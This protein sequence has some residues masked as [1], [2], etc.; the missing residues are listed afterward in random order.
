MQR[1]AIS[2]ISPI[3]SILVLK[4]NSYSVLSLWVVHSW[5]DSLKGVRL[6]LILI[7]F[8]IQVKDWQAQH[9]H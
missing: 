8:S 9:E 4:P 6:R 2:L 1:S 7:Q 3:L 5:G